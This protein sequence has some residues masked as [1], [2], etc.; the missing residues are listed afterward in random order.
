MVEPEQNARQA[1]PPEP[2][3][4]LPHDAGQTSAPT[5]PPLPRTA[6][7]RFAMA[8]RGPLL[9]LCVNLVLVV[10]KAIGGVVSGSAALLAD[11]GHSGADVANNVLVLGSLLYARRPADETHPYGHDRAEVLAAIGSAY[12]L[13]AAGLYFGWDSLQKLIRGTPTPTSLA[14]WV[15]IGTL[16][17]KVVVARMETAIARD[18]VSQAVLADARDNLAD[19]LSSFAVIIGVVGARLGAHWLDGAAGLAIAL[20]IL[21]TAIH[22]AIT[23]G[24]EL[25]EPNLS[26]RILSRVRQAAAAV[27]GVRAVTAVTGHAHGSDILVELSVQVDPRLEV[28]QAAAIADE[29]RRAIYAAVPEV[30][31][32]TVEL[33]TDHIARLRGRLR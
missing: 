12:L 2:P 20:L 6:A 21:G 16:A 9:G 29:I 11:A 18:V 1:N 14:V 25:L 28:G 7:E 13:G 17:I 31:D 33:N 8:V 23:A 4:Q 3:P 22:I 27:A 10:V 5:H 24:N 15:A 26:E 32:A 30:G 19:V